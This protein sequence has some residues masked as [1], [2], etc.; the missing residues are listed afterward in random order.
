MK[1]LLVILACVFM[2]LTI[3]AYAQEI[4]VCVVHDLENYD[5]IAEKYPV[6]AP[7]G[8]AYTYR[9]YG[10]VDNNGQTVVVSA[11]AFIGKP[12]DG[13]AMFKDDKGNIGFFDEEWNTV[14]EPK[15]VSNGPEIRFSEG[16][17][18]VGKRDSQRYIVWG[19]IDTNGN[20]VTDFIYDDAEPFENGEA[21]VGVDEAVFGG[22]HSKTKWGKIDKNGN[23]IQSLKFGYAIGRDYEYLW[24]EPIEVCLTQNLVKLNGTLYKNT[25]LEYPFINYFGYSYMPL[26]YYGMRI[27]GINCDWTPEDGVMLSGGGVPSGDI[28]GINGMTEG[29]YERA[30]FYKGKLSI[31]GKLYEYGDTAFPLIHYRNIVYIPVCWELGME[32]LGIHYDFIGPEK[33]ENSDRGIMV[34]EIK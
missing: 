10:V 20:E 26:T 22:F 25:D 2:M 27:L 19:Y 32:S 28:V 9:N 24:Q 23:I 29:V 3:N 4:E 31:N 7:H 21:W 11:Y 1:K 30:S 5:I 34:F 15:Y 33:L 6:A 12:A 8:T 18:A 14:I 17:A 13:R 16:L